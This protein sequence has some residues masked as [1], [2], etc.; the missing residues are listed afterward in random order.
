MD[1]QENNFFSNQE[2]SIRS[3]LEGCYSINDNGVYAISHKNLQE[4][5][6]AMIA[7][8]TKCS[9]YFQEIQELE[10]ESEENKR[11]S[12]WSFILNILF[13]GLFIGMLVF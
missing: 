1:N 2:S 11:I 10:T 8:Q 3:F 4:I 13:I 7:L 9:E 12:G 5:E 6:K